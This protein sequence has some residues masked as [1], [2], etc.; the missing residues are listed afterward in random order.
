MNDALAN[1]LTPEERERFGLDVSAG[2]HLERCEFEYQM[3]LEFGADKSAEEIVYGDD[4]TLKMLNDMYL[5]KLP[6]MRFADLFGCPDPYDAQQMTGAI[7]WG[8]AA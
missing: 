5:A 8:R 4:M 3:G 7:D 2:E 1:N 6:K